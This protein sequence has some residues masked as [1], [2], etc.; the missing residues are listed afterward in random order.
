MRTRKPSPR[1]TSRPLQSKQ[2]GGQLPV[3]VTGSSSAVRIAL[4]G[5]AATVLTGVLAALVTPW[6]N[7]QL[8]NPA[9]IPPAATTQARQQSTFPPSEGGGNTPVPGQ[10]ARVTFVSP[11][12]GDEINPG[13]DVPVAGSVTGLGGNTLWIL[14]MHDIGG[15]FYLV[16]ATGPSPAATKDGPWNITDV[17]VGDPSDH[18]GD[19]FYYPVQ[20]NADCTKTL[21]AMNN[22]ASFPKPPQGCT[23]LPPLRTV[24]IK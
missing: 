13:E 6:I 18:G 1:G 16:G 10:L 14:S 15:S 24:R 11:P 2:S 12:V 17:G 9:T 4:I 5:A 8:A 19:V 22:Y 21:S 20:A 3:T 7:H 23:T